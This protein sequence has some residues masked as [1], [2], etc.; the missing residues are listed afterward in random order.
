[1]TRLLLAL[2]LALHSAHGPG[3][4]AAEVPRAAIVPPAGAATPATRI[5]VLVEHT[6]T[7]TAGRAFVGSLRTSL[8]ASSRFRLAESE[9]EAGLILVV[10][11]VT[12]APP[13]NLASAISIAYV[14]NN[15][16]R[17]L[18]GSAA[19]FVGRDQAQSMGRATVDELAAVLTAYEDPKSR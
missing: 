9:D 6:G 18:L 5:G 10:V 2:L 8:R 7:D 16:W 17:S 15:D 12:P 3:A 13:A 14:A 11:S 1:M 19:R 4:D